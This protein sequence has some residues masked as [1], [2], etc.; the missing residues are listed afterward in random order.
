ME[1]RESQSGGKDDE[2]P[3]QSSCSVINDV[4]PMTTL[5][6][7]YDFIIVFILLIPFT[8]Y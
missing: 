4:L 5:L 8:D 1:A 6:L 2:P 3:L 7:S